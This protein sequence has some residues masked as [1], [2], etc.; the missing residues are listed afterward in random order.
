MREL[1]D[2][3]KLTI[4]ENDI[5]THSIE[6]ISETYWSRAF[7]T[8]RNNNTIYFSDHESMSRNDVAVSDRIIVVKFETK[9]M[10]LNIIHVYAPTSQAEDKE[11]EAFFTMLTSTLDKVP[12]CELTLVIGDFNAKVGPKKIAIY[13]V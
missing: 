13:G 1:V 12:S 8:S 11:F 2:P 6:D 9:P 4:V 10:N 5:K 7:Y 3:G